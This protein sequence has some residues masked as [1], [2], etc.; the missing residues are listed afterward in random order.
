M[1]CFE[2]SDGNRCFDCS[3]SSKGWSRKFGNNMLMTFEQT[4]F[5]HTYDGISLVARILRTRNIDE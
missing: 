4:V 1:E 2:E 3:K 5:M